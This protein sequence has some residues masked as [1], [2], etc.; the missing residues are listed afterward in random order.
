MST[1]EQTYIMVKYVHAFSPI[2]IHA[3]RVWDRG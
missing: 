1:T 2:T 3:R